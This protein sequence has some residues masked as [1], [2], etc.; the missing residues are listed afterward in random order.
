MYFYYSPSYLSI[1]IR[2]SIYIFNTQFTSC[3]PSLYLNP[4]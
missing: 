2:A 4:R 3:L 1:L